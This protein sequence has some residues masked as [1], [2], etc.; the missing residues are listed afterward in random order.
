MKRFKK[1]IYFLALAF[2]CLHAGCRDPVV[3]ELSGSGSLEIKLR[4]YRDWECNVPI[5]LEAVTSDG[6][7]SE[8]GVF[9]ICDPETVKSEKV[10][11]KIRTSSFDGLF[12]VWSKEKP[13]TILAL[14][15][16]SN[17]I[18]YPPYGFRDSSYYDHVDKLILEIRHFYK[19]DHVQLSKDPEL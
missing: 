14:V 18:V 19:N 5:Y 13:D 8:S 15:D 7:D 1:V 17:R 3:A 4:A 9:L 16:V 6:W 10:L 2:L 11:T 12:L